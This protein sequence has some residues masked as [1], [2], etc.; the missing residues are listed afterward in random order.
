MSPKE[1]VI[2]GC[3][4]RRGSIRAIVAHDLESMVLRVCI[5]HINCINGGQSRCS[6][7]PSQGRG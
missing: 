1:E 7:F 4:T 3:N 2:I 6:D 5:Y